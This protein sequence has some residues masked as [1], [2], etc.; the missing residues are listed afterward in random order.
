VKKSIPFRQAH[1]LAGQAVQ[2][3]IQ[4]GVTLDRLGLEA[5][6]SLS[7]AFEEDV[8]S[9][10]DAGQSIARRNS[11]GGTAPEAVEAQMAQAQEAIKP[12]FQ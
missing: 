3:A 6:R 11:P 9:V 5:L 8:S 4:S 7:P 12:Y 1:S 2:A 10:F